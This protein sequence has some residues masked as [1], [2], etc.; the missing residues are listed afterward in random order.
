MSLLK[1]R[2]VTFCQQLL[3]TALVLSTAVAAAGVMTLEIVPHVSPGDLRTA[4][5][6][7]K[8]YVESAPVTP[9]VRNVLVKGVAGT[10]HLR[11]RD[12]AGR[13]LAAQT[14]PQRVSGLV[15]VGATW[16]PGRTIA[17]TAISLQVRSR[18][19]GRWSGWESLEYHND[20]APDVATA[21]ARPGTEP[22]V[23]GV[24]QR[25]QLRVYTESG[26]APRGLRFALVNPGTG[27]VTKVAAASLHVPRQPQQG[28]ALRAYAAA[29]SM[30]IA[31]KPNI[32]TRAQWGADESLR[33][34][35]PRYGTIE[36]AFVHHTVNAND[37]TRE[38]V[39]ALLRSIYAYHVRS[40][41]WSDI[42][43]NF[44]V[45]RFGQ[46]W[47]GRYG[48][49]D[50]PVTGAH[51][52]GYNEVAFAMSAI[53]NYDIA[54]PP[55]AIINAYAALFAWK[56]SMYNIPADAMHIWVKDRYLNAIN[57][58][59]DTGSTACP[60]RYLY[61]RI[62]DIRAK[63]AAIQRGQKPSPTPT[64]TPTSTPITPVPESQLPKRLSLIGSAWPDL[65][66][67]E[68]ATGRVLLRPTGGQVGF[69]P[70]VPA[71]AGVA[72]GD[73]VLAM[74][75]LNKDGRVDALAYRRSTGTARVLSGSPTGYLL[76]KTA[77][78]LRGFS[79]LAPVGDFTGDGLPDMVATTT[80]SRSLWL[81]PGRGA[82]G[83]AAPVRLVSTWSG[84]TSIVG[85]GDL[86]GDGRRDLVARAKDGRWW[87]F[88]GRR[89]SVAARVGLPS[90]L[91]AYSQMVG[92]GDYT[93]D[94]KADLLARDA[95]RVYVLPGNGRLGFGAALGPFADLAPL[96]G[97]S[98]AT[99]GASVQVIGRRADGSVVT[100]KSNGKTNL[101][102][103]VDTGLRLTN[104]AALLSVGDWNRDGRTDIVSRGIGGNTLML[105]LGNG[106]GGFAP[107]KAMAWGFAKVSRLAAVGDINGDGNPDLAA[108]FGATTKLYLGNGKTGVKQTLTAPAK[109]RTYNQIGSGLWAASQS[110]AAIT[111]ATTFLPVVN[112]SAVTQLRA[113]G[114][115]TLVVGLGDVDGDQQ[116]DVVA[117]E[118]ST[119]KLWLIP[120][121]A[122]GD[123]GQRR[124][125][126]TGFGGY[127][128]LG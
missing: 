111:A 71:T 103:T 109:L 99:S 5:R 13:L 42:G 29:A 88:P 52:L 86:N 57:G 19:A 94:G 24:V 118:K 115:Y 77:L 95:K 69:E 65:V 78:T 102:A 54:E 73:Q 18:Q 67:H 8:A 120:G 117:V 126:A 27:H 112:E 58:H 45:D 28:V 82:A 75:D 72:A 90:A 38:Q 56:L 53:G 79:M 36:A 128:V 39:P 125:I 25:V 20:H 121:S 83:F 1:A 31:P 55:E 37:Y 60:G 113:S 104:T 85:A 106:K 22:T 48:G 100:V 41:G 35:S 49:I 23:V 123:L 108:R 107:A 12:T 32:M 46:I 7:G 105:R 21:A 44:L 17:E 87:A 122:A 66:V 47:E 15:T 11:S 84:Y 33:D 74:G 68:K 76:S 93:S 116:A 61:A 4:V 64:P 62:P 50:K 26:R 114:T 81:V 96:T 124:L 30:P 92:G 10:R 127:D 91:S 2:Y 51:T 59:R 63:A 98:A 3:A 89:T 9:T 97:L 101:G 110:S 43:Y 80:T 6:T 119:G 70:S 40:R 14:V 34:G 16:A